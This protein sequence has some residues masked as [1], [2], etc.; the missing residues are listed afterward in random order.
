MSKKDKLFNSM[1]SGRQDNNILFTDLCK[2]LDIMA[3]DVR[4][5]DYRMQ[6]L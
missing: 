3:F 2:L 4:V 1:M 5:K 6:K